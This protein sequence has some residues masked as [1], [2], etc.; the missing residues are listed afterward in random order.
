MNESKNDA[1]ISAASERLAKSA[2][3]SRLPAVS[4]DE[5]MRGYKAARHYEPPTIEERSI[6]LPGQEPEIAPGV[7]GYAIEADGWI[8]IPLVRAEHEGDGSVGRFLDSLTARCI[9]PTVVSARL[10]GMLERRGYRE[11]GIDDYQCFILLA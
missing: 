5:L 10:R 8:W 3:R 11:V 4:E 2:P 6:L 1:Q 9:F 7:R